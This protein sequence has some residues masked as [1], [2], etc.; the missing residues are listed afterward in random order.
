MKHPKGTFYFYSLSIPFE[1]HVVYWVDLT[2]ELRKKTLMKH[3]ELLGHLE[4]KEVNHMEVH[5][6]ALVSGKQFPNTY[7]AQK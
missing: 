4:T 5:D 1:I 3:K 6:E 2:Q 7:L